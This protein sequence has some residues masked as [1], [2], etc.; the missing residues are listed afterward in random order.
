MAGIDHT[1]ES[2][3]TTLSDGRVA[4]CLACDSDSDT[5]PGF[6]AGLVQGRAADVSFVLD[7]LTAKWQH[8]DL[9]DRKRIAMAGQS[10]GGATTVPAVVKDPRI[11]AG[12]DMDGTT[13]ARIPGSASP[14][15]SCSWVRT[16][17][18]RAAVTIRGTVT[19]SC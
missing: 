8:F 17:M 7:Q 1:Y 10:I 6:G 12:I 14:G 19:G 2:H 5:D 16:S 11:R 15:R 4:E 3:A 18:S 13:Y 9:I